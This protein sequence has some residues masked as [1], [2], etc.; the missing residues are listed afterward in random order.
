MTTN[1]SAGVRQ[2]RKHNNILAQADTALMKK[3]TF[4]F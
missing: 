3:K 4:F 1:A 2:G